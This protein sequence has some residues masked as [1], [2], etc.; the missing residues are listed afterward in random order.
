[1]TAVLVLP[2]LLVGLDIGLEGVL[3]ALLPL[4]WAHFSVLVNVLEGLDKSE[5]L[6]DVSSDWKV[7]VGGVSQDSLAI[8]D[9]SGSMKVRTKS[10]NNFWKVLCRSRT[11]WNKF[12]PGGDTG[13]WS[14]GDKS[15]VDS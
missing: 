5:N 14:L 1:M 11:P 13:V 7:V 12:L 8:N 15:S 10:E 9:E 6:I 4:G 3:V 2:V